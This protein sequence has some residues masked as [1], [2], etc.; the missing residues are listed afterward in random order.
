MV[1]RYCDHGAYGA[2]VV[3]GSISAT[4]LTVAA[5]TS[6]NLM[7]GSEIVGA[8]IVADTFITALGTGKGGTGTYTV[9]N[10]QT[11]ALGT[12]ITGR[13][14]PPPIIPFPWLSPQEGDGL[15]KEP[16]TSVGTAFI[17]FSAVPTG[18]TLTVL[19]VTISLTGVTG[20]ATA[21][22]A[23]NALATN[24]NATATAVGA[25]IS[26]STPAL[27]NLVYARGPTL[28][29][30]AGTCQIMMRVGA[31]ALDYANNASCM[32]A[33]AGFTNV[34]S[35][36]ANHQFAG[37]V[38]GCYGT[39]LNLGPCL[40]AALSSFFYGLWGSTQAPLGGYPLAGDLIALRSNKKL[41]GAVA[42]S[43]NTAC[44]ILTGGTAQL[45]CVFTVDDGTVW[46]ED[47]VNPILDI[48]VNVASSG[49]PSL[50]AS[51]ASILRGKKYADGVNSLQFNLTGS[52]VLQNAFYIQCHSPLRV[53]YV[54]LDG[55]TYNAGT[56]GVQIKS[57]STNNVNNTIT[58]FL[59]CKF[60]H[61][62][63][64]PFINIGINTNPLSVTFDGCEFDNTGSAAP[65]NGVL[66]WVSC[67][68]QGTLL[69]PVF[70]NDTQE[71][72]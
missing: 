47:G 21:L 33:T 56:G 49:Y 68:G 48:R 70:Y 34:S 11:V 27:R 16:S 37:G 30:P 38:S 45:P 59:G 29:A 10:S 54:T 23:A 32:I 52:G 7:I 28:G 51:G 67:T 8:G 53:E 50:Y 65:N 64:Y 60:I 13:N 3:T 69:N 35:T 61:K 22:A 19:G 55:T 62:T 9:S 31:P 71:S 57:D 63:N 72:E 44:R 15:A 58:S 66:G 6:G 36:A 18:T 1:N 4:T 17:T 43:V 39:L 2:G 42:N 5:V 20:A 41:L 14:G 24:I 46:T 25:G 12:T 26:N 40:A